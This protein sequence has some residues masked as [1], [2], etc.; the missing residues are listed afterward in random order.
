MIKVTM[1]GTSGSTPTKER[2]MPSVA[3]TYDGRV[4]LFDC[5][6]GTQM[7]MLTFGINISRVESIFITHIHGD[8]VIGLAGLIRTMAL[9]N[10]ERELVIHVPRGQ[11]RAI[12]DL[13][14][15]DKAIIRYPIKI[16]GIGTGKV[17]QN[18][19]ISISAFR[20]N[21]QITTYGYL[22]AE[23]DKRRFMK[24]KCK[25]LGIKGTMFA[26]L[27]KRKQI[28]I[29]KRKVA[30]GSVS[31]LQKGKRIVYATDTRPTAQTSRAALGASLLVHEASYAA[32]E[33]KLAEERKH[34][35]ATEAAQIAKR[36]KISTLVLTHISARYRDTNGMLTEARKIFKNTVVATDGYTVNV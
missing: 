21:H 16:K 22:F 3:I 8:H 1:L 5:G 28:K 15:F 33:K 17:Y 32:G 30:L 34:S 9:N 14:G 25:S 19:G 11:E 6:E 26:E 2:G 35:T 12:H 23:D 4:Y 29:G 13:I 7:K 20:L 27:L 31:T 10:R 18:D 24:E 36:A